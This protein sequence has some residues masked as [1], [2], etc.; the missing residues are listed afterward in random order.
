MQ[1]DVHAAAGAIE[2][3]KS[4]LKAIV[5]KYKISDADLNGE[6]RSG[7]VLAG[8]RGGAELLM[9][10]T[11]ATLLDWLAALVWPQLGSGRCAVPP[12]LQGGGDRC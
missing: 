2:A 6:R 7:A 10:A 5:G 1:H 11:A 3:E 12:G 8:F 4:A 9:L